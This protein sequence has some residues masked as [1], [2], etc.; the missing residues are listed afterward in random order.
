VVGQGAADK[1]QVQHMVRAL[2]E[3]SGTPQADAADA[4]ACA[5]CHAHH[6]NGAGA[7]VRPRA[8]RRRSLRRLPR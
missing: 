5:V 4:L 8:R 1:R 6:A 2:L 3:L 7:L